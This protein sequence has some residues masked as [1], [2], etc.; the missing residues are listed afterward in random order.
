MLRTGP[1][2]SVQP[3]RVVTRRL[4]HIGLGGPA[5]SMYGDR[6][7]IGAQ[8]RDERAAILDAWVQTM[9]RPRAEREVVE[10][11]EPI[12]VQAW[13]GEAIPELTSDA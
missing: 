8:G 11:D 7:T 1:R 5:V 4:P 13:V 9:L 12:R 6:S 2:R 10:P 3:G